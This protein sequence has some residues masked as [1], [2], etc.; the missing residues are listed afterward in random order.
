MPE[1]GTMPS[2]TAMMPNTIISSR[3]VRGVIG[4]VSSVNAVMS[5]GPSRQSRRFHQE[6]Q[7]H[8][9]EHHGVGSF[10]VEI[11]GQS[12]DHPQRKTGDDR[13]HDRAHAA[14]DDDREHDNDEVGTHQRPHLV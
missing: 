9:H 2:S 8:Q 7:H 11:F 3:M 14:D 6:H 1:N 4:S 10:G 5:G 12:L 13:A